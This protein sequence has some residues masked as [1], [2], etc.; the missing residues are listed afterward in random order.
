MRTIL[1]LVLSIP[2]LGGAL[3]SLSEGVTDIDRF[4]LW[5]GCEPIDLIVENLP[6]D[7]HNIGLQRDKII[8][9]VRSRLRAAQLYNSESGPHLYVNVTVV[10]NAYSISL[11]LRKLLMDL[12]SYEIGYSETWYRGILGTHGKNAGY[13][14]SGVS[15]KTDEFI[16]EYYRVNAEDCN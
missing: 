2:L 4:E 6:Q 10:G 3:P 8:Y 5:T 13:I 9:N 1:A 11:S 15:Q 7:A 14:L 16:D 12:N